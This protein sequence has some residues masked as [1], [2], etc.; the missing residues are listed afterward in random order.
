MWL[1]TAGFEVVQPNRQVSNK[2]VSNA[3]KVLAL[4]LFIDPEQ[5]P[6]GSFG[7]DGTYPQYL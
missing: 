1:L 2:C 6:D 7:H 5:G 4:Y 3:R